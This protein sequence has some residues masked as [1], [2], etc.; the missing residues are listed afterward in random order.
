[1]Y[2]IPG[3]E[4]NQNEI[5]KIFD[6]HGIREILLNI[7]RIYLQQNICSFVLNPSNITSLQE[8]PQ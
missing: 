6:F 1:M 7:L 8:N 3:D 5:R 2:V 4:R